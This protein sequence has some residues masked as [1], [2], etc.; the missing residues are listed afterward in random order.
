M[1]GLKMRTKVLVIE[2][3]GSVNELV[4]FLGYHF[5]RLSGSS[6]RLNT[7][8]FALINAHKMFS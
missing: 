6:Y 4:S 8:S 5:I 1:C 3:F 2:F 7:N